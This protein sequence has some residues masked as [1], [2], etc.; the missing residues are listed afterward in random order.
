MGVLAS[1]RETTIRPVS[2]APCYPPSAHAAKYAARGGKIH[3]LTMSA[4]QD[5]ADYILGQMLDRVSV[6]GTLSRIQVSSADAWHRC[7]RW[8][9]L[10]RGRAQCPQIT[11]SSAAGVGVLTCSRLSLLSGVPGTAYVSSSVAAVDAGAATGDGARP[12]RG[13]VTS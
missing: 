10:H 9:A 7:T 8:W 13:F 3:T 11:T 1:L 2:I 6:D 12:H 5:G 4:A